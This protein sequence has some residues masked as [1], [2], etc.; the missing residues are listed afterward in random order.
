MPDQVASMDSLK[1]S[2]DNNP[3]TQKG[4]ALCRPVARTAHAIIFSGKNDQGVFFGINLT[5]VKNWQDV[6]SGISFVNPPSL[7]STILLL[8]GRWQKFRAS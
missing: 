4:R 1:A 2:G 5:G 8:C 3:Y 7:P 6:P